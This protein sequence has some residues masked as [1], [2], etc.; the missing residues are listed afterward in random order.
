MAMGLNA[1]KIALT[2]LAT[3]FGNL[4][5]KDFANAVRPL[6]NRDFTP[7]REVCICLMEDYRVREL[8]DNLFI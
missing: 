5:L 4:T 1:Q 2:V 3:G 7:V 6:L 8:A